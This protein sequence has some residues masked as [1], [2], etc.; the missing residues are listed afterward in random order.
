MHAEKKHNSSGYFHTLFESC[1]GVKHQNKLIHTCTQTSSRLPDSLDQRTTEV[2]ITKPM[3]AI[4]WLP[5]QIVDPSV[6]R[7]VV[8][9]SIFE[10]RYVEEARMTK[11]T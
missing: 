4:K 9:Y 5:A 1:I 3:G 7:G 6:K 8:K 10:L 2:S 11:V